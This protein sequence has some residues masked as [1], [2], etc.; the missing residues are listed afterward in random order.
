[1]TPL[2]VLKLEGDRFDFSFFDEKTEKT[3]PIQERDGKSV[4]VDLWQHF[5]AI[6]ECKTHAQA[7]QVL[8]KLE[9]A[10]SAQNTHK[11]QLILGCEVF[12]KIGKGQHVV[13]MWKGFPEMK[14]LVQQEIAAAAKCAYASKTC[15]LQ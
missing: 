1:M 11:F 15:F 10:Q 9:N 5:P 7:L 3:T 13:E 6:R 12:V 8:T 2:L 14:Q 4:N